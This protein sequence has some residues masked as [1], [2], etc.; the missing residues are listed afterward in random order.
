MTEVGSC[1]TCC[2]VDEQ[3]IGSV[4]KP[5][6]GVRIVLDRSHT[7][8]ALRGRV[9]DRLGRPIAG[10]AIGP[11]CDAFHTRL[12]G[13][14]ISTYHARAE[15]TSTDAEGRFV[16]DEVPKDLVYLRL[17]GADTL[18]LE[19]GR[20]LE[21]GLARLVGGDFDDLVITVG[22]RAHFQVALADPAEADE[23]SMLDADAEDRLQQVR[24]G[25]GLRIETEGYRSVEL[26]VLRLRQKPERLVM[27][28]HVR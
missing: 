2:T 4:G 10:V 25:L 26:G 9:V 8:P 22:R 21:G 1:A 27:L 13:R 28:A 18:P 3:R 15:G 24:V 19:W 20:H 14:V 17:D 12:Q 16:L 5:L 7:W 23:L 6:P 11:M